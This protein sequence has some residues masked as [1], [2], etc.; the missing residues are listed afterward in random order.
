MLEYLIPLLTLNLG[1]IV[2]SVFDNLL[3]LFMI[4]SFIVVTEPKV[5]L[6]QQILSFLSTVG[7]LFAILLVFEL[8]GV[9]IAPFLIV[10]PAQVA[11]HYFL[12]GTKYE[13]HFVT[14]VCLLF[15]VYPII[16]FWLL[17]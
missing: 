13:K 1:V 7:F 5:G 9:P 8:M 11:A 12:K 15:F 14:V 6:G 10:V 16:H 3:W 4:F 2:H 17:V